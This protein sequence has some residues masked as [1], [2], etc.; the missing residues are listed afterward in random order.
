[1]LG[2]AKSLG[3]TYANFN[4]VTPYPGTEFFGQMKERIVDRDFSHYDVYT[5]VL[6][7]EYLSIEQ[8]KALHSKCFRHYYFRW[9]YLAQNA[10]LLFPS[11]A[12]LGMGPSQR[13]MENADAAHPSPPRPKSGLE[14]HQKERILRA[15]SPHHR[16]STGSRGEPRGTDDNR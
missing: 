12:R 11:L 16:P 10:H 8:V 5:P 9:P 15:D 13:T 6:K 7:Y 1:V 14:M 2:Y 4:V 3:P